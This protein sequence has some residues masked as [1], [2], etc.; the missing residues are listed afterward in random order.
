MQGSSPK[1]IFHRWQNWAGSK[2]KLKWQTHSSLMLLW[3][4]QGIVIRS[5]HIFPV[6]IFPMQ[7]WKLTSEWED[8]QIFHVIWWQSS[9]EETNRGSVLAL[10]GN[11]FLLVWLYLV[12]RVPQSVTHSSSSRLDSLL[13]QLDFLITRSFPLKISDD[14]HILLMCFSSLFL[15]L[16]SSL[17]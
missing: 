6:L 10:D 2:R 11:G 17:K 7:L 4:L 14:A 5:M 9:P 3:W 15:S 1:R 16:S 12:Y 8:T 13:F